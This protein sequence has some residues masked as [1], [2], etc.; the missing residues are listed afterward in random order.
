LCLDHTFIPEGRFASL[1]VR[2][3]E[4]AHSLADGFQ[5]LWSKP[6]RD[7]REIDFQRS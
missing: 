3:K 7:L 4:L 2:D 5:K 6:M 1:L